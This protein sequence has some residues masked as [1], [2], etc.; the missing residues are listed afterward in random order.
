M[1]EDTSKASVDRSD[2]YI[3]TTGRELQNKP[4]TNDRAIYIYGSPY[5][6]Y[7]RWITCTVH[8]TMTAIRV[9]FR[10]RV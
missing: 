3:D 8:N 1:L 9:T 10:G 6:D 4:V 2:A 7:T 5:E